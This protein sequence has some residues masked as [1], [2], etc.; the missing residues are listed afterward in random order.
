M[1]EKIL[2]INGKEFVGEAIIGKPQ[3]RGV[4]IKNLWGYADNSQD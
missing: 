2:R 3:K 4:E 1:V